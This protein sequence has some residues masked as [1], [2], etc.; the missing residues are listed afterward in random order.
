[1]ANRIY[2]KVSELEVAVNK[3]ESTL[4]SGIRYSQNETSLIHSRQRDTEL[5]MNPL[6]RE[7][8]MI[9]NPQMNASAVITDSLKL[10]LVQGSDS[11]GRRANEALIKGFW[12]YKTVP[13]ELSPAI[14]GYDPSGINGPIPWGAE[15]LRIAAMTKSSKYLNPYYE[16]LF[17][18]DGR[19]ETT[20]ENIRALMRYR[21][22]VRNLLSNDNSGN[23]VPYPGM[24]QGV[25]GT[26]TPAFNLSRTVVLSSPDLGVTTLTSP[27][28]FYVSPV[29]CM[30]YFG[31]N[32]DDLECA[33]GASDSNTTMCVSA[34]AAYPLEQ[35]ANAINNNVYYFNNVGA[36]PTGV[37]PFS[38]YQMYLSTD[39]EINASIMSRAKAS[40][41][42]V[43]VVT[44][45]AG[46]SHAAD[47]MYEFA[48]HIPSTHMLASSFL[49]DPVANYKC[50]IS[51]GAVGTTDASAL[52]YTST[53]TG[54]P[55]STLQAAY[56]LKTAYSNILPKVLNGI[57][58]CN[59]TTDASS[60]LYPWS[61]KKLAELAHSSA[62]ISDAWTGVT[63][64]RLP[65]VIKGT[66]NVSECL[67]IQSSGADGVIISNHGGRL[68]DQSPA[69]VEMVSKVRT[70]VK[71]V[72]ASFGVWMDSGIRRGTDV[73]VA[74][75]Q[76]AEFVGIGRPIQYANV[77]LG[78]IGIR[79][80]L[81][82][83]AFVLRKACQVVGL[84]SLNNITLNQNCVYPLFDA[85]G[86]PTGHS[87]WN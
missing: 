30:K 35:M 40:G 39:P 70:A 55:I 73:L 87:V 15:E 63:G 10:A 44:I 21:F 25:S 79:Q 19:G 86:N 34:F 37:A 4:E 50:W 11:Y 2:N 43:I 12:N 76:G 53:K 77:V 17:A 68:Y 24:L 64:I 58:L 29:A 36:S 57:R 61:V 33:H 66:T 42:K 69:T 9:D 56:N 71:A 52:Q 46:H 59:A 7:L 82:Q 45:D 38:M 83:M 81:Q 74:Y 26:G 62:S 49:T 28:P 60:A 27:L 65:L 1:M 41:F 51:T 78:R 67:A 72:D 54:T 75:S 20:S 18:G 80:V 5:N 31:G 32:S 47:K 6:S 85:S 84:P 14:T 8:A 3:A 13:G 48:A 22:N 23:L 16:E